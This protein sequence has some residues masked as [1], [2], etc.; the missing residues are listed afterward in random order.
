MTPPTVDRLTLRAPDDWHLHLRDGEALQAVI[1]DTARRFVRA[2]VMPNTLPPLRRAAD[3]LAYGERI[4]RA[5]QAACPERPFQPL[6]TLYLTEETTEGDIDEAVA[7]GI[8]GVKLYPAGATTNSSAG[9]RSL[10]QVEP[11][12]AHMARVGLPL[13]V[14][15]EVTDPDIDIFDRERVFLERVLGPLLGRLPDLR[16]VV[17]HL[18]T[19][20]AVAFVDAAGPAVG[21]TLTAH[22]LLAN[23]ND[24]LVG[25]VRPHYYCLPV[26]KRETDRQALLEAATRGPSRYFLGTDSA[27]HAVSRK[28]AI[29]GCAGC[30]TA[31]A[32]IELYAEAFD[33]VG[34]LD[35]LE[36]FA[37]ENGPDFYRLPRNEGA[38]TLTRRDWTPP[39]S[40]P[41]GAGAEL[42]PWRHEAPVRW[43]L[44]AG[45]QAG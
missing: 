29:C 43:A 32:G 16:V 10:S 3:A 12:L 9:V 13:L 21:A 14:H 5:R 36:A 26:L 30:Y 2:V 18:T 15:G 4:E 40:L 8:V 1:G 35:R 6:L 7:A 31:H 25:G 37:S 38:V 23:R 33:A 41:F 39:A 27:P 34:A 17:E 22:H 19:A 42:R 44:D 24:L 20:A 11:V 28:E 45:A